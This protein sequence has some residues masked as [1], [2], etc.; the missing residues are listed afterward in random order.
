MASPDVLDLDRLLAPLGEESPAGVDI[1]SDSSPGSLYYQI[2]DARTAAR[3]A[4]RQAADGVPDA[5]ADWRPVLKQGEKALAEKTKDLEVAAFMIEALVRLHGFAGLREGFKL[6]RGLVENF[7]D[8]L[9]PTP[10][11][12]GIST[13][14]APLASLNGEDAEGVLI[15]PIALVPLTDDSAGGP[16]SHVQYQQA[17]AI[18]QMTDDEAKAR[19][20]EQVG[21]SMSKIAQAVSETSPEFYAE[22][23]ADLSQCQE[24]FAGLCSA[25]DERC[26]GNAPPA[27][28]IRSALDGCMDAIRDIARNKLA[29]GGAGAAASSADATVSGGGGAPGSIR[30]LGTTH[31]QTLLKVATFFGAR[32]PITRYRMPWSKPSAGAAS[33]SR[34]F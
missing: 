11:E 22:L 1:R 16:F 3:S 13:R 12:D 34:T 9:Y 26:G 24:E 32:S 7:W 6:A 33:P 28:N 31:I 23:V 14:V 29:V 19:R 30:T 5:R 8:G 20:M 25:L 15:Q 2:K 4:E 27:S 17:T 18:D 21:V 10:D